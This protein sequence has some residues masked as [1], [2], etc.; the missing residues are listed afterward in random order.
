MSA[1][2]WVTAW[3]T[4][5]LAVVTV[6][7]VVAAFVAWGTARA[8]LDQMR[9]DSI[10]RTRPYVFVEILPGLAGMKS[11]DVRI[12][13]SGSSAARALS[14][15]FDK[16]PEAPD[17]VAKSVRDLFETPR[18]LPPGCSIRAIWRVEGPFVDG[19]GPAGLG[20]QGEITA[21][22]TSDD[23]S[24]P[25]YSD[26]FVVLIDKSGLWPVSE[27]GPEPH[28][29]KTDA[30]QRFYALGRALVRRVGELGR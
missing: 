8:T 7:L 23:P 16:W 27:D 20:R 4:V 21:Q 18:T 2:A 22:Y 15:S 26:Q 10:E 3:A 19:A 24:E 25:T 1:A 11:Y 12:T 6:A 30:E 14:L 29:L 5:A 17:D 9:H 13:N 28:G